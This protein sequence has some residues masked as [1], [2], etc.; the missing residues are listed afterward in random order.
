MKGIPISYVRTNQLILVILTLSAVVLQSGML[1]LVAFLFVTM[2]LFIGPKANIAFIL[3]K[4]I[5]SNTDR[6][7]TESAELQK[8]NQTIAAALLTVAIVIYFVIGSWIAWIFVAMVTLAATIAL[9]G[10]C[11]GCVL[12][13]QFKKL[14]YKLSK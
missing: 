13:F 12:Y 6:Q 3:A 11:I 2:P 10:F 9:L 4:R 5:Y 8:F 1:L 14:K 7:Q